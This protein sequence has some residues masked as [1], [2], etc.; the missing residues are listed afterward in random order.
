MGLLFGRTRDLQWY[1]F[2]ID[3]TVEIRYHMGHKIVLFFFKILLRLIHVIAYIMQFVFFCRFRFCRLFF[4]WVEKIRLDSASSQNCHG[5]NLRKLRQNPLFVYR[6]GLKIWTV[7]SRAMSCS[8]RHGA[9]STKLEWFCTFLK[10]SGH[11][12]LSHIKLATYGNHSPPNST[13]FY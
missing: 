11:T 8:E 7:K 1:A 2:K 5:V 13:W 6:K 10:R 12:K 9:S 4:L 3:R